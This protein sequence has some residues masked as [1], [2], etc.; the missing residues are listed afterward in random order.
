MTAQPRNIRTEAEQTL[1]DSFARSRDRLPGGDLVHARRQAAI[2]LFADRGLPHRRVEEWKYTDLRALMRK[3][4]P[5]ASRPS[6]ADAARAVKVLADP[7]AGVDRFRL[8]LVDGFFFDALSDRDALLAAGIEVAPLAELLAADG[9]MAAELLTPA[10]SAAGDV[11]VALNAAFANDGVVIFVPAGAALGK[12]LEI[13][14]VSTEG[15]A[16]AIVSRNRITIGADASVKIIETYRGPSGQAYQV[17]AMSDV[18][19]GTKAHV[20][21]SRL[22]LDG[23]QALHVGSS[24]ISQAPGSNID[25]L[26]V[27]AGAAVSRS[28]VFLTTGG[29]HTRAAFYGAGMIG[30]RQH[31]DVSLAIDHALPGTNTRVLFKNAIDGQAEGVFQ[32][33]FMVR[34]DAQKTDA[35]MMSQALLLSDDAQFVAKPELEIFADDVRC[36][37]GATSG[38]IDDEMLFYLMA[39]GVPRADAEQL[40]I[41]AFLDDAIDGI[42]DAAIGG[43]FK[44][45]VSDWL[46]RRGRGSGA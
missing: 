28:Q 40:L 38:R 41:E 15:A 21:W 17:N 42:G 4:A 23:D 35:N 9:Q 30:G 19:I 14:H 10:D 34:R 18:A 31:A 12:P 43:A 46:E 33:K 32:G 29:E 24:T 22:Q 2:D 1:L 3:A 27:T 36:G 5:P 25:H 8:V 16:A 7:L 39:R 37:H 20:A 26:T 11:A 44:G 6:G 45:V 13:A